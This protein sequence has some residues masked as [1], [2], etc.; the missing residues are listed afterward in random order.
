MNDYITA[1]NFNKFVSNPLAD[2][3]LSE[4]LTRPIVEVI[5]MECELC[6]GLPRDHKDVIYMNRTGV[7]MDCAREELRPDFKEVDEDEEN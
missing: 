5:H 2:R 6:G 4:T 1:Q 7:C 3:F